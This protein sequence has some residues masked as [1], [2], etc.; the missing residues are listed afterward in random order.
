M[1]TRDDSAVAPRSPNS[2]AVLSPRICFPAGALAYEDGM[3]AEIIHQLSKLCNLNV[4]ARDAVLENV[5][6]RSLAERARDL[7]VQSILTG[8]FQNVDGGIRV[9]MSPWIRCQAGRLDAGL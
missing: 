4:I 9:N 1:P 8:T 2:V 3:D 6:D 7:G 5:G